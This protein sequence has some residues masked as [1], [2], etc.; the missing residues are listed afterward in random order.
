METILLEFVN[1]LETMLKQLEADAGKSSGS[2]NLTISQYQYINT[3]HTLG[4]PSISE[5]A[6]YLGI[7]K[8]SVTAG[9]NRLERLGYVVKTQSTVDRRVFHISLTEASQKLVK[10]KYQALKEYGAFIR[11]A[12]CEEEAEQFEAILRKLVERFGQPDARA[13]HTT[14]GQPK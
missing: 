6:A 5:I 4:Q 11:G 1:T 2:A 8:A 12:L 14:G 7:T 13:I 10:A 3:V 9:I